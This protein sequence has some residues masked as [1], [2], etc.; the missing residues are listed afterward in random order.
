MNESTLAY[1][2]QTQIAEHAIDW[3][4]VDLTRDGRTDQ[5]AAEILKLQTASDQVSKPGDSAVKKLQKIRKTYFWVLNS[6]ADSETPA[7][8]VVREYRAAQDTGHVTKRV[9]L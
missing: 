2:A 7:G 6:L 1:D 9:V 3:F 5:Y 4:K 8:E